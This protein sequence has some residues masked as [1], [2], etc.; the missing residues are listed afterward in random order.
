ML[1]LMPSPLSRAAEAEGAVSAVLNAAGEPPHRAET[2]PRNEPERVY[3]AQTLE[4]AGA[5]TWPAKNRNYPACRRT[6]SAGGPWEISRDNCWQLVHG[7]H[8][9]NEQKPRLGK[10]S[11]L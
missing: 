7:V 11:R 3:R 4:A 10:R 6:D 8:K 9:P 1:F 2:L 5:A